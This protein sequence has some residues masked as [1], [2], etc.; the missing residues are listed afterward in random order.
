MATVDAAMKIAF[1]VH[2][3][4]PWD[5]YGVPRYIE[6]L[7]RALNARECEIT[8]LCAGRNDL[9]R[10]EIMGSTTVIR[11]WCPRFLKAK[12]SGL[13]PLI[14]LWVFSIWGVTF[15]S[16]FIRSRGIQLIH[17]HTVD[18]G[19]LQAAMMAFMCRIPC[20]LTIHGV[21]LHGNRISRLLLK[22]FRSRYARVICQRKQVLKSLAT[23]GFEEEQTSLVASSTLERAIPN[24][25]VVAKNADVITI[26]FVG[27]LTPF[28]NPELFVQAAHK[29]SI[30]ND[31]LRFVMAGDGELRN[32]LEDSVRKFR[33]ERELQ[34]CGQVDDVDE[35]YRIGHIFVACS[36]I[37]N[38]SSL[39][40]F[41]AMAHGL[42]IIATNV[43]ETQSIIRNYETGLLIKDGDP[44]ALSDCILLLAEDSQLRESLGM[45]AAEEV[46][47]YSIE[48]TVLAHKSIYQ[49]VCRQ[50]G[51]LD[52]ISRKRE[53]S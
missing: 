1:I 38:F 53:G 28:K 19:G 17:G 12:N 10:V 26:V 52:S 43:G 32:S 5:S 35:I 49:I 27:R 9:P 37:E 51:R 39:S 47:K 45:K 22:L 20:I 41:E 46:K 21:G 31:R 25:R 44:K 8:V 34:L 16:R 6:R 11:S 33:L 40:L 50:N 3:Y 36:S 29:A 24:K 2:G 15:G 30:K 48:E 18:H 4:L 42:A 14:S 7:S 23:M 13:F